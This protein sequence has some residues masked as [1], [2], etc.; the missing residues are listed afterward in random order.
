M[1][2]SD[3]FSL[4][5]VKERFA[6]CYLSSLNQQIDRQKKLI[7][8]AH[9]LLKSY[10]HRISRIE[11]KKEKNKCISETVWLKNAIYQLIQDEIPHRRDI[12]LAEQFET[13]FIESKAFILLQNEEVV[14]EQSKE[15]FHAQSDDSFGLKVQKRVKHFAFLSSTAPTRIS[16]LF[17]KNKKSI[18]Y[19]SHTIPLRKMCRRYFHEE[20]ILEA[21]DFFEE[22]QQL[23]CTSLNHLIDL[24]KK[25]NFAFEDYLKIQK[26]DQLVESLARIE[27][28]LAAKEIDQLFEDK[29]QRWKEECDNIISLQ[30]KKFFKAIEIV[31][32]I[33]R[34]SSIYSVSNENN[35]LTQIRL[36]YYNYFNG[37]TNTKFAQID[38]LQVDI[39]LYLIKFSAIQ[40]F[41]LLQD[42]CRSR[43]KETLDNTVQEI[44]TTIAD[45]DEKI[46][47]GKDT[48][49]LE[50]DLFQ[51]REHLNQDLAKKKIPLAVEAIYNQSLPELINRYEVKIKNEIAKMA[52]KRIVYSLND[53]NKPIAKNDL[54]HFNP[55]E[56]VEADILP[57]FLKTLEK[58]NAQIVGKVENVKIILED[59]GGIIDYN[60]EAAINAI[61]DQKELNEIKDIAHEGAQR[62]FSKLIEIQESLNG[63]EA[64][65]GIDLKKSVEELNKKLIALTDNENISQVRLK[66]AKA[67]ALKATEDYRKQLIQ[68]IKNILPIAFR[69][70][71]KKTFVLFDYTNKAL[72]KLGLKEESQELTAALSEY[73]NETEKVIDLLPYVYKRLYQI[74]AL[75]DDL[76]FEGRASELE[77]LNKAFNG[78][79]N[80]SYS[81]CCLHGEKGSG[82]SSLVNLFLNN[83]GNLPVYRH[84]FSQSYAEESSFIS[85][86]QE[87]LND[88]SL[89][90][91]ADIENKLMNGE[92]SIIVLE[93]LQH[94][95]LKKIHGFDAIKLL[96]DLI[97]KTAVKVFWLVEITTYTYTY[98]QK[99]LAIDRYFRYPIA[100]SP[101]SNDQIIKLIMKRHRVSGYKLEFDDTGLSNAE[102]KKMK[103]LKPE[104]QQ[105]ILKQQFFTNLNNFAQSNI[106]LALLFWLRSTKSVE[107][108]TIV[109][110]RRPLMQFSFLNSL[111]NES[112][113]TLHSFLLH[114]SLN[115]EEH[116]QVFHQSTTQSSRVLMI[117]EDR[118]LLNSNNGRYYL[119]RLLYRQVVEMLRNRN[120]IH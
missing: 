113:F 59:L 34:S 40:Q 98:L 84:K 95:Y 5:E 55:R 69:Y 68:N 71:R 7:D 101:L 112:I 120:I 114:D 27:K 31:D 45:F 10:C 64:R 8:E 54:T 107:N 119:N 115:A 33:E 60:I 111:D 11:S 57:S 39:E 43:I 92:I 97:A 51:A 61:A 104:Q 109:M 116:A 72:K 67:K 108:N 30:Y 29:K 102:K 58:L 53:Y 18:P 83:C 32:T 19:W 49:S 106:S 105:E 118:G 26:K 103:G 79:K 42:S 14:E 1:K 15:R 63:V 87:L 110:E 90:S 47:K 96:L 81:A 73:L 50:T 21:I 100:L 99:T 9:S 78:W 41:E 25:V 48:K 77:A 17:S 88:N 20:F 89:K 44:K 86:F 12:P 74:S 91:S 22:L 82:A 62:G 2:E 36:K 37:W 66:I 65:L 46:G 13:F 80:G 23:Y 16:N 70:L 24:D 94:F 52:E 6:D 3:L 56:L 38:D 117:L 85:F 28:E 35:I 76:F 4:Q 93:D 75:K